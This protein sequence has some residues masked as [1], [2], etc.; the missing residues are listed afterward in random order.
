MSS[1]QYRF[2]CFSLYHPLCSQKVVGWKLHPSIKDPRLTNI[3]ARIAPLNSKISADHG[4]KEV[5]QHDR[6]MV[7]ER[8]TYV[9]FVTRL[10]FLTR[11][12]IIENFTLYTTVRKFVDVESDWTYPEVSGPRMRQV[13]QCLIV[14][15]SDNLVFCI[16]PN[17]LDCAEPRRRGGQVQDLHPSC[18]S[19][20]FR[21]AL[22][23]CR[24]ALSVTRKTL[25]HLRRAA[26]RYLANVGRRTFYVAASIQIC[27]SGTAA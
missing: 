15:G 4:N 3:A 9:Q 23:L 17:G 7:M 14:F 26:P 27:N 24:L 5:T 18:S 21:T 25:P 22:Y 8:F 6:P 20:Y 16:L 12:Q 19:R 1:F 13:F 10:S 2:Q 11:V